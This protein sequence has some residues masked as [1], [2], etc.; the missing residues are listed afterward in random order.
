MSPTTDQ[1][2]KTTGIF[3]ILAQPAVATLAPILLGTVISLIA[4]EFAQ[5]AEHSRIRAEFLKEVQ[6]HLGQIRFK[7]TRD[8][9]SM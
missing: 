1:P 8:T 4:F 2:E 6:Y 5:K 3:A 7:I 9:E